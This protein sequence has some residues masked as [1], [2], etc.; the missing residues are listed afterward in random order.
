[1]LF[2]KYRPISLLPPFSKLFERFMYNRLINFI[3]KHMFL[4]QYQFGFHRN[5]STF[6]AL[7]FLLE[8]IITTLDNA[9]FAL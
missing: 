4:Y 3:E 8:K 9:E 1:M 6:M 2:N 5:Y 7:V